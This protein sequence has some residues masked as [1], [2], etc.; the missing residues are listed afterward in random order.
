MPRNPTGIGAGLARSSP[1]DDANSVCQS[2]LAVRTGLQP[3]LLSSQAQNCPAGKANS[4]M[5]FTFP[6]S[7]AR[8]PGRRHLG[9]CQH[10]QF[11]PTAL[12]IFSGFYE[13]FS[14][15]VERLCPRHKP[16]KENSSSPCEFLKEFGGITVRA[17]KP[18]RKTTKQGTKAKRK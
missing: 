17:S 11:N 4:G 10:L 1:P 15:R 7:T 18:R 8:A 3:S 9:C 6:S 5:S 16:L 12:L 13:A 2:P 14:P